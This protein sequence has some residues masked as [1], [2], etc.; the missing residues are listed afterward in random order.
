[1]ATPW[2]MPLIAFC[3]IC[4]LALAIGLIVIRRPGIAKG[5]LLLVLLP[6]AGAA[7]PFLFAVGM[8]ALNGQLQL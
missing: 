1:M 3:F 2:L 8:A 5:A 7:A 4:G 6:L